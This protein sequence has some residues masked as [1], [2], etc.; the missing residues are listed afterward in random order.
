MFEE[1]VID[2]PDNVNGYSNISENGRDRIPEYAVKPDDQVFTEILVQ[3]E[4]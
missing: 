3:A 4:L 2:N 1:K